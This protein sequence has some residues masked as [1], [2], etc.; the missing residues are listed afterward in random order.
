MNYLRRPIKK[1]AKAPTPTAAATLNIGLR[2]TCSIEVSYASVVAD[3]ATDNKRHGMALHY[4]QIS[5]TRAKE[6]TLKAE[7]KAE[8]LR[9]VSSEN[10]S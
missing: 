8:H 6:A 9:L 5:A 1:P 2:F 7:G 4:G 10:V 3:A